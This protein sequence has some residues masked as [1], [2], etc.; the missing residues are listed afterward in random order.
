VQDRTI[1]AIVQR[2]VQ[3]DAPGATAWVNQFPEGT[4]RESA[5]ATLDEFARRS[6]PF[7]H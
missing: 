2:W 1:V 3:T 5:L 7:P 6:A 4:L